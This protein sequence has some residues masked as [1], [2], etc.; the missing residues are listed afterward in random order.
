MGRGNI[1]NAFLFHFSGCGIDD[2]DLPC[3][4]A[5][6][7]NFFDVLIVTLLGYEREQGRI[8]SG[9]L[10]FFPDCLC[11]FF[12]GI[13]IIDQF[14]ILHIVLLLQNFK[15]RGILGNI[16]C[17]GMPVFGLPGNVTDAYAIAI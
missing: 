13:A 11:L 10:H 4:A 8:G 14:F 16:D 9:I 2:R 17:Y 6:S 5:S 15:R 1:G 3:D 7:E 12:L